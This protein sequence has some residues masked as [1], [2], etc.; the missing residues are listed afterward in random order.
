MKRFDPSR[1]NRFLDH[2][3]N[4]AAAGLLAVVLAGCGGG[5]S[6]AATSAAAAA[7]PPPATA[8]ATIAT[9]AALPASDTAANPAAA[10]GVVQ[11]AGIVPVTINSPPR[12]N[13]TVLSDGAVVKGL[14]TSNARF[15]IA[16][17]VPGTNGAPDQ[18]VSYTH[19]TETATA[20]VG[21]AGAPVL[22]SATQATTDPAADPGQLVYN[23]AGYYTYT[24][25]T[26][27]KDPAKTNGVVFEPQRTHRIAIQLSYTN[28]AG[29]T[30][31]VNPY[32]DFTID[33]NGN[34]VAVTDTGKDHK[35][36]DI[37]SCNECHEKLAVHGGGRVDTQFCVLCHNAGTTDANSG[38]VLDFRIMI[39]K[40]HAGARLKE[41]FGADYTVWG[42]KDGMNSYADVRFPQELRNCTKCH[43]GSK[44]DA[45]GKPLT[46]QGDNW[47]NVPSRAACGAC[48]AGI[49]FSTGRGTT[50]M[51]E[52][53][54]HIGG[55]QKDD[56]LCALCHDA[57]T[58]PVYHSR[59]LTIATPHNPVIKPGVA[60]F[61]YKIASVTIDSSKRV[62]VKFQVLKDGAAVPFNT[63][64][65]GA[66][67]L[68]GYTD[69][70]AFYVFYATAQDGIAAP[71]DW[72]SGHDSL[73]LKDAWASAN[74]NSLSGPD[75]SNTY[76]VTIAASST[77]RRPS[78][79]LVLPDDAKMVTASLAG[80]FTDATATAAGALPG[81]SAMM[82][83]TGNT[84]DGKPNVARRTIF[85]ATSCNTCHDRL[86]SAPNFHGGNYS[87]AMCAGCHTPNQG[88]GTGW[89][90]SFRVW[91]HGIHGAGKRTVPFTWQAV[92]AADNY[93]QIGYPGVLKNCETCH[94]PGTYDFSAS[95]YTTNDAAGKTIVDNMLYVQAAT[96]KLDPASAANYVFPQAAPVASGNYAYGGALS[97]TDSLAL[98]VD[99]TTDF[100]IG[101]SIDGSTGKLIA[102]TTQ[103]KNLVSSPIAAA[104]TACHDDA[105]AISHI[106]TTGYGSFY[107]PRTA[108]LSAPKEQ[109]LFCHGP[110][111]IVPIKDA[112]DPATAPW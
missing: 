100:G 25:T 13:F 9:A 11:S 54:G 3:I 22:A 84:P 29:M 43:D 98:K 77:G 70:P 112:H 61:E 18:W 68:D 76:T 83:A 28:K 32:F 48:H 1:K 40:I 102:Q 57:T 88:G 86:G 96:G 46:P 67:L 37:G 10:F 34:A 4:F 97:A 19:R 62:A 56:S 30:V 27:I 93:S 73:T 26:D 64:A 65:A 95:Q 104:C 85:S 101:N 75:A 2:W 58:I 60:S 71:S 38:N 31:L 5:G 90:A 107:R 14:T 20:T 66:E 45:A 80:S 24:F 42:Y 33:A 12:V 6:T 94:L 47:K 50:I 99:N 81:I 15:I 16:K 23:D 74:G 52:T 63:Y 44:K 35:V 59:E 87:I 69:G 91:V 106:T 89:S 36:V 82:A 79:S 109:C 51:G 78:H 108:A 55:A 21:P 72:N 103:G 110:G 49:D 39:H 53:T 8:A 7:A 92:S 111:K 41:T 17:L 105:A